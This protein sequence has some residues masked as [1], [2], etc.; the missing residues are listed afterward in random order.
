MPGPGAGCIS[1]TE[2]AGRVALG[3]VTV[4]ACYVNDRYLQE[5]RIMSPE[6]IMTAIDRLEIDAKRI[7]EALHARCAKLPVSSA[8]AALLHR[9]HR[10]VA[11]LHLAISL[12]ARPSH[13]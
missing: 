8:K 12:T 2:S 4:I 6:Q 5:S 7:G 3:G 1:A 10:V 13:G 9:L 11:D